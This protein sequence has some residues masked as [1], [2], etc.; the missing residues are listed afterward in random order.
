[1]S[2]WLFNIRALHDSIVNYLYP[3]VGPTVRYR[4]FSGIIEECFYAQLYY[5]NDF[6][7]ELTLNRII[8]EGPSIDQAEDLKSHLVE[9][10]VRM[11]S[12]T[13][14]HEIVSD[15][16]NYEIK[17]RSD[18]IMEII[19][20]DIHEV[21]GYHRHELIQEQHQSDSNFDYIPPRQ[22]LNVG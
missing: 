4:D 16:V 12:Y 9:E 8:Q 3:W 14:L 21:E 20:Y 7:H 19:F 17:T 22:R 11:L 5:Y 15:I 2:R 6:P 10:V 1:M 18:G 13:N